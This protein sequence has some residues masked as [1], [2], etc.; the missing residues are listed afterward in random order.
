[1]HVK[2]LECKICAGRTDD[3]ANKGHALGS[4]LQAL[5][6]DAQLAEMGRQA[7][8]AGAAPSSRH[9]LLCSRI[10]SIQPHGTLAVALHL[11]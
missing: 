10:T 8:K 1:M 2:C 3:R 4:G 11:R 6:G 7:I 5:P 9:S